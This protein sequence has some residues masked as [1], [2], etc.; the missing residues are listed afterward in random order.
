MFIYFLGIF[1][2]KPYSKF[3]SNIESHGVNDIKINHGFIQSDW[4]SELFHD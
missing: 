4:T 2:E 1:T 3:S